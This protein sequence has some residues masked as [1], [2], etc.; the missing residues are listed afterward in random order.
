MAALQA[1]AGMATVLQAMRGSWGKTEGG[2]AGDKTG[3]E[4][5]ATAAEV[6]RQC[7]AGGRQLDGGARDDAMTTGGGKR[8]QCR[9]RRGTG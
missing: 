8:R 3:G 4:E 1:T 7:G 5:T 6:V 2:M 9:D